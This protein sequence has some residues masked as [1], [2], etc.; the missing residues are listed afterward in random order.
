MMHTSKN[1]DKI[2]TSSSED[3]CS[4]SDRVESENCATTSIANSSSRPKR[5]KRQI[6]RL[7]TGR[8]TYGNLIN[9]L[10]RQKSCEN[11]NVNEH[12][13]LQPIL[14]KLLDDMQEKIITKFEDRLRL[15]EKKIDDVIIQIT[16]VEFKMKARRS[17]SETMSVRKRSRLLSNT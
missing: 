13:D 15:I 4:D 16:R 8:E 10:E 1:S 9:T 2:I 12:S 6:E 14:Q 3:S 11:N 7:G 5:G 17:I